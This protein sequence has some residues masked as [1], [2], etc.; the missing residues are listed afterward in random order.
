MHLCTCLLLILNVANRKHQ[1]ASYVHSL[2]CS[3]LPIFLVYIKGDVSSVLAMTS[4]I[5]EPYHS[6]DYVKENCWWV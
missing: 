5:V 2:H 4:Y 1:L 6:E 3:Q